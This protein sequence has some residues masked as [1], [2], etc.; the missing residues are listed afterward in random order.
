[1]KTTLQTSVQRRTRPRT[2]LRQRRLVSGNGTQSVVLY[3]VPW[4]T[5]QDLCD[6]QGQ[7]Y[8]R[9]TYDR[10]TL[11]IMSVS[12]EHDRYKCLLGLIITAVAYGLKRPIGGFGSF[13]HRRE[14]LARA[15]EPDQCF[16]LENLRKVAAKRQIDLNRD[17]PPDLALEIEISRSALNRLG[18]FAALGVPEVWRFDGQA[19]YVHLL[20]DGEYEDSTRSRAFPEIPMARLL[21]FLN[22]DF[23]DDNARIDAV[24]DWAAGFLSQARKKAK[25]V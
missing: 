9:M 11:E 1:M 21:D 5:Y 19:I 25:R 17:P 24:R 18:I 6:A 13:T 23:Q 3:N 14:D 20:K 4:Q 8:I 12:L 10:G 2:A 22:L 16:Y 15:L 7:R